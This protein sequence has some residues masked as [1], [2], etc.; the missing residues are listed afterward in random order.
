MYLQWVQCNSCLADFLDW[1]QGLSL[2]VCVSV[3]SWRLF[4]ILDGELKMLSLLHC[5]QA[6]KDAM[7]YQNG[8][9]CPYWYWFLELGRSLSP[10]VTL[11]HSILNFT[12]AHH[13]VQTIFAQLVII[14]NNLNLIWQ[15]MYTRMLLILPRGGYTVE[16]KK[17]VYIIRCS[18]R[19][20]LTSKRLV[21]RPVW[22]P[23]QLDEWVAHDRQVQMDWCQLFGSSGEPLRSD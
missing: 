1:V 6:P 8:N 11:P 16:G 19:L 13:K 17:R 3:C 14:S 10:R 5:S 23:A 9:C 20:T 12:S 4:L 18:I 21:Q 2:C 22:P 7:T 15:S